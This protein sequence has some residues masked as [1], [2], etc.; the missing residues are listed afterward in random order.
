MVAVS[1]ASLHDSRG[2][3][4]LVAASRR[5]W[6]FL[7]RCFADRAYAGSRVANA[8]PVA[9]TLVSSPLGQKGFAVQPRRWVVERSF[10]WIGRCSRLALDHEATTSSAV[11]FFTLAAVMLL[12]R[13]P[14]RPL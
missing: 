10:A 8:A 5:P 6:P 14:A 9:V 11:A 1:P 3:A 4:A 2:G 13:R 7:S 12:V